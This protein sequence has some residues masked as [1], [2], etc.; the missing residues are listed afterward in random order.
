M[1]GKIMK[2]D[3][4]TSGSSMQMVQ[5]EA[6]EFLVDVWRGRMRWQSRTSSGHFIR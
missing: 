2:M 4:V 3:M 1:Y 5:E 6:G